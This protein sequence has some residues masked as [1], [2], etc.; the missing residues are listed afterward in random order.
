MPQGLLRSL[1]YLKQRMYTKIYSVPYVG[2]ALQDDKQ[3]IVLSPEF[4][5]Q[6]PSGCFGTYI[7]SFVSHGRSFIKIS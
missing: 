2:S 6:V 5:F 1:S 3:L 7:N 4:T